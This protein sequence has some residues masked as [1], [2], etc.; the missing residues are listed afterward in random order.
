MRLGGKYRRDETY[1]KNIEEK[2]AAA[3]AR[4]ASE[5]IAKVRE[6]AYE[7]L[8]SHEMTPEKLEALIH[9][10]QQQVDQESVYNV[11]NHEPLTIFRNAKGHFGTGENHHVIRHREKKTTKEDI[12]KPVGDLSLTLKGDNPMILNVGNLFTEPG[13]TAK[14]GDKDVSDQIVVEGADQIDVNKAGT[15]EVKYIIEVDDV[16]EAGQPIK[17]RQE[18]IRKVEVKEAVEDEKLSLQLKGANPFELNTGE[19]FKDP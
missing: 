18:K 10:Y 11:D 14:H 9:H 15:Y 7:T 17:K 4:P 6:W 16:D 12:E 1:Q 2:L 3:K 13:A 8:L 5:R 19:T